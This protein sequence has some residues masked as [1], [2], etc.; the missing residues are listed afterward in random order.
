MKLRIIDRILAV[1]NAILLLFVASAVCADAFMGGRC[2]ELVALVLQRR[3]AAA[4]PAVIGVIAVL[5]ARL[6]DTKNIVLAGTLTDM[7]YT[8]EVFGKMEPLYGM[9]FILPGQAEFT[10]SVGAALCAL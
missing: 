5:A 9:N 10:T 4:W 7:P 2:F 1:I 8:T 6:E 3:G